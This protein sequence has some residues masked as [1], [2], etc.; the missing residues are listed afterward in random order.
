MKSDDA[1]SLEK[2]PDWWDKV[3]PG[4]FDGHTEFHRLTPEE[5]LI[6]LSHV[7]RFYWAANGARA[8]KKITSTNAA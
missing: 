2:N 6:W 8:N 3:E 5:R 4:D 7:Q 1:D